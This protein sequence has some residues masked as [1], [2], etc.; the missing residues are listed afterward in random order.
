MKSVLISIK[1]KWCELIA[2]GKKTIEVRKTKPRIDTPFK[3]Y[4]YETTTG[5]VIGEFMCDE[6]QNYECE[7]VDDNC[8]EEIA[9]VFVD[10][11]GDRTGFIEWSNDGIS[12]YENTDL[13]KESCVQYNDLKKYMGMGFGQFYGWHISELKMYDKP[14]ELGEFRKYKIKEC[15]YADLGLAKRDCSDCKDITCFVSRPPQS[16]CYV[17]G[18]RS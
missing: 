8:Y 15:W 1:P 2:G 12:P 14:K 16:W 7:F 5:K 13:Y 4:I 6:I 10:E 3:C 18:L 11:D 9:S 17:E